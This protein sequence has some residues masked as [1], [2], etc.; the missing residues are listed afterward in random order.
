MHGER[1]SCD[2]AHIKKT[3]PTKPTNNDMT[4]TKVQQNLHKL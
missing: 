1:I 3:K 4:Y 2:I